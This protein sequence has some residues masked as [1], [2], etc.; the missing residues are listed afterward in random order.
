MLH[1][2]PSHAFEGVFIKLASNQL[3]IVSNIKHFF[4][5]TIPHNIAITIASHFYQSVVVVIELDCDYRPFIVD[6]DGFNSGDLFRWVKD[7]TGIEVF[8]S[9]LACLTITK[10]ESKS[11]GAVPLYLSDG[12]ILK[13]IQ[14]L[15]GKREHVRNSQTCINCVSF[16]GWNDWLTVLDRVEKHRL[17]S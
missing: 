3:L 2:D 10:C 11:L 9:N 4:P 14:T 15:V 8:I 5:S 17:R 13:M 16:L 6:D 1:L 12:E 7:V